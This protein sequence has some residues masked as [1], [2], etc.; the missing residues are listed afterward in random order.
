MKKLLF[1]SLIVLSQMQADAKIWRVNNTAG[2]NAD[3]TNLNSAISN[4]SV[5]DGDTIHLEPSATIYNASFTLNKRLVLIGYGYLL[6][7]T[8]SN[9]GLQESTQNAAINAI[10]TLASGSANSKLMG[11]DLPG[12]QFLFASG[13]SGNVNITFE[14]C[15]INGGNPMVFAAGATYSGVSFRKCL[16]NGVNFNTAPAVA[17]LNNLTV[18]NCIVVGNV[19]W[20]K[21]PAGTNIVIRNNTFSLATNPAVDVN[22]AYVANNIFL[23]GSIQNSFISCNV[24]N[25]VFTANQTG[26]TIGP[27]STNGNNL[28]SQT[29]ASLILNTGSDDGKFQLAAGSPAIGGGVD[30]SGFKPDCGAFGSNDPYKLSG[31]PGIPTIYSL[32][33]PASIPVGTPTMN[34]TLSTRNN[35]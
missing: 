22:N 19:F 4:A 11:I 10:I 26:V 31:I 9:T 35:N 15:K 16:F 6:T 33:V 1:V 28:V 32:T 27:L 30:I 29:L 34:V 14:K 7:G 3:F 13:Y 24:K 2:I 5:L 23:T 18:E 20:L 12:S 8:G 25:N 21:P 17:A